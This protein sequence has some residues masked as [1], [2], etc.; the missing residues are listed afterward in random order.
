MG[1]L[2]GDQ[3]AAWPFLSE[4]LW[5]LGSRLTG[6]TFTPPFWLDLL[7]RSL[8]YA[9]LAFFLWQLLFAMPLPGLQAFLSSPYHM[10]AD[11]RMLQFFLAPGP[12]LLG[13]LLVFLILALFVQNPWCRYL[14]PYGALLGLVSLTSLARITRDP[15][16]CVRCNACSSRCPA[17]LPVMIKTTVR[18][19]E[20]FAC[21]RCVQGCPA[22]GALEMKLLHRVR[23]PAMIFGLVLLVLFLSVDLYGRSQGRWHNA[24]SDA[25]ISVLIRESR[26]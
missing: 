9:I 11:V 20:C 26:R 6:R 10:M 22:P 24:V 18:S 12:I 15:T 3:K 8:K 25:D 14:C 5:R 23:L 2:G 13:F 7:L 21:Y 1:A 4:I 19:P 17:W 16:L